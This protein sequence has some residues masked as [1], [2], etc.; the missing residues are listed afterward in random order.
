M[1]RSSRRLGAVRP[2]G[3]ASA[4]G[5]KARLTRL[6]VRTGLVLL[7]GPALVLGLYRVLP[8]PI[9][10]LML[11]RLVEGEGLDRSWRSLDSIAPTLPRA[12]IAAEDNQFC[13]HF[14][15][16]WAELRGQVELALQGERTRGASTITMQVTRNALLWPGRDIVRKLVELW[17]TPQ[18]ELLWGKRRILEIYLNIVEMGPGIYGAEAAAQAYF[19]TSAAEL[20]ARQAALIAAILP[21]PRIYSASEPSAYVRERATVIERRV[22]QLGPLLDCAP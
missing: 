7:L 14:G 5:V 22:G 2:R 11:V 13:R 4:G 16:D 9:T 18:T 17:L 21:N 1:A 20:S 6:A 15:F 3:E 12:L 8:P 10:P 19:G